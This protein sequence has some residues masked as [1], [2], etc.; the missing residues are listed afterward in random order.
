MSKASHHAASPLSTV[1]FF[2]RGTIAALVL[3]AVGFGF[4]LWRFIFGIGA[5]A[6]LDDSYPWGLW[7][8][9][10]VATGVALAAGG[11]T[12]SALAHIF[13]RER[14]HALVRPALL[15]ALLG[16]TF[17]GI[18]LMADLGRYYSIW[19]PMIYWQGNSVLF[20]VGIC[21]MC[22]MTVLYIE[23]LPIV[24]ERFK[25]GVRFP[26][27]LRV[28]DGLATRLLRVTDKTLSRI[29]S[30]FIIMGVVL[31]C[32]HQSSLGTL[33]VI[34][35]TKIHPLWYTP[36]MPLLFWLSAVA[37]GFPMVI[38]EG[39]WAAR[40]FK[41]KPE[42]ELLSPLARFIP[43]FLGLY[44]AAKLIDLAERDLLTSVFSFGPASLAFSLEFGLGV[45]LP[46][47]LLLFKRVRETPSYL[48]LAALLIVLGVALNRVNVFITA[49]TP[50]FATHG[51][52]PAIGEWLVTGAFIATLILC[53]RFIVL[54]FPVISGQAKESH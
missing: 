29:L 42:M 15:T 40:S 28:F 46:L 10:D 35:P 5:V 22:Y 53:Y 4:A 19:H 11:F 1:P 18:G 31:S 13:H 23:F 26:G 24:A 39:L 32:L 34:A 21:V 41:L 52:W 2:S 16:Y 7:I 51:Y 50:P 38:F 14:Y 37:V 48:F 54:N 27:I 6:N 3:I 45:L 9:I 17:V 8:G 20:E 43:F 36:I 25:G 44:A 12:T 30:F 47:V 33:M 49:Y